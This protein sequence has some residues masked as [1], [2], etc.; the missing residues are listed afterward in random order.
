ML[1]DVIAIH[2]GVGESASSMHRAQWIVEI[3]S[4]DAEHSLSNVTS[5]QTKRF[6][7][8]S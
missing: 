5:G 8:K 1:I 4:D 2:V 6:H 7:I 3:I